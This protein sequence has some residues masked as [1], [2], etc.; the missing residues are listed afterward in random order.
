MYGITDM[1]YTFT[2]PLHTHMHH[3]FTSPLHTLYSLLL[4]LPASSSLSASSL[5]PRR[6]GNTGSGQ[7]RVVSERMN[8]DKH[9]FLSLTKGH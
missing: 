3:T 6:V 2:S 5:S 4:S 8:D 1:H 7:D 9:P